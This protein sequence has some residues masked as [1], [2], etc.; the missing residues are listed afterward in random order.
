M[1][2][3]SS[4]QR[5]PPSSNITIDARCIYAAVPTPVP[6]SKRASQPAPVQPKRAPRIPPPFPSHPF[7]RLVLDRIPLSP[8]TSIRACQLASTSKFAVAAR[9]L[10]VVLYPTRQACIPETTRATPTFHLHAP[11]PVIRLLKSSRYFERRGWPYLRELRIRHFE[12]L[13]SRPA[14]SPGTVSSFRDHHPMGVFGCENTLDSSHAPRPLLVMLTVH[15]LKVPSSPTIGCLFQ[16]PTI[17]AGTSCHSA[18]A[19]PSDSV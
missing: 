12:S 7:T 18:T 2:L 15:I 17:R 4:P 13:R 8:D 11:P 14:L 5:Q 19:S 16:E 10:P 6:I 1:L 3:R 9:Q